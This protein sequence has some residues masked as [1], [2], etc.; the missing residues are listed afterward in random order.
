AAQFDA[1]SDE[2]FLNTLNIPGIRR[3]ADLRSAAVLNMNGPFWIH[4]A[5][6]TFPSQWIQSVY[7]AL[8]KADA[9]RIETDAA[10]EQAILDWLAKQ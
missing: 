3:A 4:D 9:L 5:A 8:G 7:Q 10:S 1:G 6:P 2:A